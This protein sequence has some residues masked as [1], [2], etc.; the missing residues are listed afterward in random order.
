MSHTLTVVS[1]THWDREWYQPFQEYRIRLV[2]MTDRL[3]DLLASDPDYRHFTFDGQTVVLEDYLEV[4]PE[5]EGTLRRY[6]QEGR[7]LIGPWHIL[8]DEFLVGPEATIRNLM[9]GDKAARQFGA[10]MPV[11]YIPDSFGHISQLPQILRGFDLDVAVFWRGVGQAPNEFRWAAPDGSEVLAIHL[12]N[13][14]GNA[15]HLPDDEEEFVA[16]LGEVIASLAPHATTSHLLAMNGTDHLEPMPGLPRLIAAADIRL[17]DVAIRHGTLPQFV[18]AVRAAKPA[19]PLRQGELHSPER[20]Q[21]L[22]GVFSARMWIK[23]RNAWCET[24]LEKWA[25]PFS[26]LAALYSM[27]TPTRDLSALTWQAWRYLIQNHPHD[28]ICGCSV[29]V[30]HKEMDV[31]FDWVEQIGEEVTR[32]SLTAIAGAVD[33]SALTGWPVVV[34][35]PIAGPRTD[36]AT[37][38]IWV[39]PD[40]QAIEAVDEHGKVV[41]CE[42]TRRKLNRPEVIDLDRSAFLG[43]LAV[44]KDGSL[45]GEGIQ[46][47][48]ITVAGDRALVDVTVAAGAPDATTLE[49]GRAQVQALLA[50]ERIQHFQVRLHRQVKLDVRFLAHDVPGHGYRTF[51]L[52][53]TARATEPNTPTAGQRIENEF[54]S[55]EADPASGTL[56]VIDKTT[57]TVYAGLHRFVD[58]GD[59]GDEYTYCPPEHDRLVAAPA[60]P[61]DVRLVERGPV[62]WT[63]EIAQTYRVPAGLCADRSERSGDDV[64]LPITTRVSLS[65]GVRRVDFVTAVENQARDH[66]LRVHFPTTIRTDVSH[67]E[68]HFD[69]LTRPVDLPQS[70]EDWPEQPV[71]THHQRTFVGVNDGQIGLLVANRGLP[72]YEVIPGDDGVTVA[73]TLL[74][75][76]GWLSREDMHCRQGHAGPGLPT[77]GAQCP[78][79]HT[80]EYAL[81]P[82][83]GGWQNAYA[84]AHAFNAPLRAVATPAS[85]GP[86]PSTLSS[87]QVDPPKFVIAALK[88]AED[89]GGLIVRGYNIAGEAREVALR[90]DRPFRRATRVNLNEV[91]QEELA[92]DGDAVHFTARAKEIVTVRFEVGE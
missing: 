53:P 79:R 88:Q 10:K 89:G 16:R 73:L 37:G 5:Q 62:R 52:R 13:S 50:D 60:T 57:G 42:I 20:A 49:Q 59:R 41:P 66:R 81:V 46:A 24:L 32:Q 19:L 64:D 44:A 84:Q 21:L 68:G 12:R 36:V 67:A 34:F 85:D 2:Q 55:V 18:A 90:L 17:P 77:P 76:V 27:E 61:P 29:D 25:E 70:T 80:F 15:A 31:R 72:E 43:A 48:E 86:L 9:L 91:P 30:V 45:W 35:N 14:Y 1:H 54:F 83:S 82:H 22:P 7:L 38:Q 3:L 40:I 6:V 23:Q 51:T 33:T 58:G 71:G 69:V 87:V 92:A 4:R 74:R 39:S 63:L 47:L 28:S 78:G 65:P 56:T 8:P 26:A 75:C 11:G